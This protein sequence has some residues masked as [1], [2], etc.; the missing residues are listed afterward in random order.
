MVSRRFFL[1]PWARSR[2]FVMGLLGFF[3]LVVLPYGFTRWQSRDFPADT[4][5]EGAYLRIVLAVTEGRLAQAFPYLETEAQW[6]CYTLH[7]YRSKA[8]QLVRSSYPE[9][10]RTQLLS[11]YGTSENASTAE[12]LFAREA[13]AKGWEGRL[14]R[15]LSG[16]AR[17]EVQADRATVETARGTRYPFRRRENGIWGLT[18]FTSALHEEAQKAS[19]DLAVIEKAAADY[20]AVQ[21][22]P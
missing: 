10:E 4:T 20:Q 6:A 14:R 13:L 16:I 5:P 7:E 19:R 1:A 11:L 18:W 21:K 2:G 15:D 3:L 12:A 9:P 8:V 22:K 17:V